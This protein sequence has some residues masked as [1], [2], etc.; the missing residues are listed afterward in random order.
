MQEQWWSYFNIDKSPSYQTLTLLKAFLASG[1]LLFGLKNTFMIQ[2]HCYMFFFF[3]YLKKV[4]EFI[5]KGNIN[6]MCFM[7]FRL[8]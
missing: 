4:I 7:S 8:V 1:V 6:Q 2:V 5:F 3:L